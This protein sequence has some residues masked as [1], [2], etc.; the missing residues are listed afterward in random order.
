MPLVRLLEKARLGAGC[1]PSPKEVKEEILLLKV[2]QSVEL[3]Y[4]FEDV[5]A[6]EIEIVPLEI[7]SGVVAL[8]ILL[9]PGAPLRLIAHALYDPDPIIAVIITLTWPV[10]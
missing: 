9:T 4:P 8:I 2:F 10:V 7:E 6:C 5:D 1:D 3:K